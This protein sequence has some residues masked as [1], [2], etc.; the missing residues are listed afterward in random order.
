MEKRDWYCDRT[1]V[2]A[3]MHAKEQVIAPLFAAAFSLPIVLPPSLNTDVFG[4]F[5]REVARPGSQ[6]EAARRKAEAALAATGL[7]LAIA[8]EGS[9][10]PH[11]QCP[12]VPCDR[13]LVLLMDRQH[14]FE[15]VVDH[16]SLET[17]YDQAEVG[18][19]EEA[20]AFAERAR[21]PSHGLVVM[22]SPV[23]GG[24]PVILKGITDWAVLTQQVQALLQT[25]PNGLVHLET[26]MRAMVNPT[27][28][29]VIEA[30]AQ[31]LIQKLQN[32]C[33]SCDCPGFAAIELVPG[34]PCG[35]CA[36]PTALIQ[37]E[38]HGCQHC[39]FR[40]TFKVPQSGQ[41]A[42]PGDCPI[43]NP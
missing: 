36:F 20:I 31:L 6:L 19:V 32:T 25:S 39:D 37:S 15:V 42:D 40:Q 9:F 28:M 18:G 13:E 5:T 3:T 10:G 11:P 21:F 7:T 27:R 23:A 34:L 4:T 24:E 30:A 22:S 35:A 14:N 2:L 1:A 8:S 16:F 33:P 29:A 38:I 41:F 43:C 17:N 12:W 26:D